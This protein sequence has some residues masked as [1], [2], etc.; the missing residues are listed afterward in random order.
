[1]QPLNLL[2]SA[3]GLDPAENQPTTVHPD[4]TQPKN[5]QTPDVEAAEQNA[6]RKKELT[7]S[8]LVKLIF[9]T[10]A[11]GLRSTE[12]NAFLRKIRSDYPSFGDDAIR[13]YLG[14]GN[15]NDGSETDYSKLEEGITIDEMLEFDPDEDPDNLIGNR[16]ICKGYQAVLQ[17]PTGVGKSSLIMQAAILWVLGRKF[18][19]ISAVKALRVMIIQDENYLGDMAEAFQGITKEL[20]EADE[21]TE[22]DLDSLRDNLIINRVTGV[23]GDFAAYLK[24]AIGRY[25]P[26]LVFV[27]PFFAYASGDIKE[28]KVVSDL[29][30]GEINPILRD[31][32]VAL[33]WNH[34]VSKPGAQ[35]NGQEESSE[36]KKY[37]SFGSSEIPNTV[38]TVITLSEIGDGLFELHFSKRGM[39][40]GISDAKTGNPISSVN[41]EHGGRRIA[42]KLA[43]GKRADASKSKSQGIKAFGMV[44]DLTI[45]RK[46]ITRS[47]LEAWASRTTGVGIKAAV[48]FA[49]ELAEDY[50][51]DPRIYTYKRPSPLGADGKK[52]KGEQPTVFSVIPPS[53]DDA[54]G[55]DPTEAAKFKASE[56]AKREIACEFEFTS[57]MGKSTVTVTCPDCAEK[58][59]AFHETKKPPG[60]A[61]KRSC[62]SL[63]TLCK[64]P[65]RESRFF[66]VQGV[67]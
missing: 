19:G 43:T 4:E 16:W 42:W 57:H 62:A 21:L 35:A 63:G 33:I 14:R 37:N 39:R 38:R 36:R 52:I 51:Q 11:K 27:D 59:W 64:C 53:T 65:D 25:K 44:R 15:N 18:F 31:T 28:Q 26:D 10:K 7:R 30:R 32:G 9:D 47:D 67:G 50:E 24:Y 41:I 34:H 5:P 54:F 13:E 1:M 58:S 3:Q 56:G 29:L 49:K 23:R 60:S 66:V 17:G 22:D 8:E 46:T 6:T 48:N 2:T 61:L 20:E 55:G 40:A 45:E 12:W